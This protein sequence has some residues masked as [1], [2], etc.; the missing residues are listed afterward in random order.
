MALCGS[1]FCG[2]ALVSIPATEGAI[3]AVLPTIDVAGNG[4]AASP[5][6]LTLNDE[7]VALVAELLN[8]LKV[9]SGSGTTDGSGSI[10]V[11]FGQTMPDLT[12]VIPV[13]E[14]SETTQLSCH[15]IAVTTTGFTMRVTRNDAAVASQVVTYRYIAISDP[16]T[17][18]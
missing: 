7:W 16:V 15:L 17:P 13:M 12:A 10:T 14:S 18:P 2:C 6:N 5:Y 9:G 3:G 11:A 4:T 1:S 8:N